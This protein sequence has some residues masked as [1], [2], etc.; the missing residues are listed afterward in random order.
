MNEKNRSYLVGGPLH[1]IKEVIPLEYD[2]VLLGNHRTQ[3]YR[4]ARIGTVIDGKPHRV[5]IYQEVKPC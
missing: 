1:G 4:S 2:W 5:F 3:L